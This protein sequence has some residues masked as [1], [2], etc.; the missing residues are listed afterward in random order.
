MYQAI[1][2]QFFSEMSTQV[3][4]SWPIA[5]ATTGYDPWETVATD[6]ENLGGIDLGECM[7][8]AM[9]QYLICDMHGLHLME[10]EGITVSTP[11]L[12]DFPKLSG[13]IT[14]QLKWVNPLKASIAGSIEAACG[15]VR[16]S[17]TFTGEAKAI[18]L[19]GT[20]TGRYSACWM[21][22]LQKIGLELLQIDKVQLKYSH[23]AVGLGLM[24]KFAP[25][26]ELIEAQVKDL[27]GSALEGDTSLSA[28]K[29][30]NHALR[31]VLTDKS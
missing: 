28:C 12:V 9:A 11:Y 8:D 29:A 18:Q 16:H 7:A 21:E 4:P 25:K 22:N 10:V 20:A 24:G 15:Q 6:A 3:G 26:A 19:T 1:L 17:C 30:F 13:T 27:L 5:L 2:T 23:I 14:Y 31:M